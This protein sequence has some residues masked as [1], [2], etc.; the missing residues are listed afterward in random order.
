MRVCVPPTQ[1]L[2]YLNAMV[3]LQTCLLRDEALELDALQPLAT[4][5]SKV[6][7]CPVRYARGAGPDAGSGG[8]EDD[9]ETMVRF[10][11]KIKFD[12]HIQ[13]QIR[14]TY[15]SMNLKS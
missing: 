8:Q 6:F 15:S 3:S 13:N 4:T 12:L 1:V 5:A 9:G 7:T 2:H 14:L 11:F 10:K